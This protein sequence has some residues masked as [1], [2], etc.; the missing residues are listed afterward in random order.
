[1][2]LDFDD[3][4]YSPEHEARDRSFAKRYRR[5][6]VSDVP[7][8]TRSLACVPIQLTS[9]VV[10]GDGHERQWRILDVKKPSP[11]TIVLALT[12]YEKN[13]GPELDS[14]SSSA[15]G[16]MTNREQIDCASG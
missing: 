1:M 6:N 13:I 10:S 4:S 15:S 14:T 12:S 3:R 16:S 5:L 9:R 8:H 11:R 7:A 2:R